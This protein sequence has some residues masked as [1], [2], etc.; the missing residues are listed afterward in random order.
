MSDGYYRK[1]FLL[2]VLLREVESALQYEAGIVRKRTIRILRDL[3][4]KHDSDSRY[5]DTVSGASVGVG[6]L[7]WTP[8]TCMYIHVYNIYTYLHI[9]TCIYTDT[10][11][12]I[13][14]VYTYR[15][16]KISPYP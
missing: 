6:C 14:R 12:G 11:S 15:V 5:K 9:C 2:G 13:V 8:A 7:V 1:H 3:L 10:E 16:N 4:A